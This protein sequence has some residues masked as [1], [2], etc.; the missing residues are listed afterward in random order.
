MEIV[1]PKIKHKDEFAE[2]IIYIIARYYNVSPEQI[3]RHDRKGRIAEA[4]NFCYHFIR[5]YTKLIF[6]D[7]GALLK[8]DHSSV[9][10]G[11]RTLTG[12]IAIKDRGVFSKYL[13]IKYNIDEVIRQEYPKTFGFR[14]S[15]FTPSETL[16]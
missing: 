1:N 7:I 8:R 13:E 12:Y 15:T 2:T 11:N 4:R 6:R 3:I 14:I 16:T 5:L 10:Q 9:V